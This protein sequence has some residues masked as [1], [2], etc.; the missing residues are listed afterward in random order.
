MISTTFFNP[1]TKS[2]NTFPDLKWKHIRNLDRHIGLIS[3]VEIA[4]VKMF[5]VKATIK[6]V[7]FNQ[8]CFEGPLSKTSGNVPYDQAAVYSKNPI[9]V[10]VLTNLN[11]HSVIF[12]INT[13]YSRC[14]F[15]INYQ[16]WEFILTC[17]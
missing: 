1:A 10:F 8:N 2:N 5:L 12:F 9:A 11:T 15:E 3:N 6:N 14:T 16:S 4:V 13:K 7:A 17:A